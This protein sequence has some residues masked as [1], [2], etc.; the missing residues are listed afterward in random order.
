MRRRLVS[1]V[2]RSRQLHPLL[3]MRNQQGEEIKGMVAETQA[4]LQAIK[5][6]ARGKALGVGGM[7]RA[8]SHLPTIKLHAPRAGFKACSGKRCRA[9]WLLRAAP[10]KW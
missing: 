8:Q 1:G 9:R 3:V 10:S 5:Q 6:S 7:H 2:T 4:S